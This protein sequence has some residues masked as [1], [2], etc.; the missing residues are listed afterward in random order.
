MDHDIREKLTS[1]VIGGITTEALVVY[2]MAQIRKLLEG[3]DAEPYGFLKFHCDWVLHAKL[4][5]NSKAKEILHQ[6]EVQHI[7]LKGNIQVD[8]LPRP[9]RGEIEQISKMRQFRTQLNEFLRSNSIPLVDAGRDGWTRFLFLYA[10]VIENCPLEITSSNSE[11]TIEKV[12]VNVEQ[13]A[14]EVA[15][16]V[17][18]RISWT[19]LDK[20][21][22]T[23]V[24]D[25]NNSFANR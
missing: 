14:E 12:T 13:A 17:F 19:I 22:Q 20:S 23:G 2:F 5:G 24:I 6:F 25:I 4:S 10:H 21:G 1:T 7:Q 16:E 3:Q 9:L 11:S 8:D 15:G 18:Y